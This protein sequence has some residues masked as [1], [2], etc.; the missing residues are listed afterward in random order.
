M[1]NEAE[2]AVESPDADGISGSHKAIRILT[3]WR[4]MGVDVKDGC[5]ESSD[6][7]SLD[8]DFAFEPQDLLV[9]AHVGVWIGAGDGLITRALPERSAW[10]RSRSS[11]PRFRYRWPC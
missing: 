1:P 11:A 4:R 9:R 2:G 3:E 5:F 8:Y 7:L 6:P 10:R